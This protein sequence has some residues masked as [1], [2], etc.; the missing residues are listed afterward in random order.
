LVYPPT[1]LEKKPGRPKTKWIPNT[2]SAS[3]KR[4]ITCGNC[5]TQ[6]RHNKTTCP[7]PPAKNQR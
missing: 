5:H 7:Y 3:F 1:V 2:C 4:P 6:A